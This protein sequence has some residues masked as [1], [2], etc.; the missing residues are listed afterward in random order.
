MN[1][2]IDRIYAAEGDKTLGGI[3]GWFD[4][5]DKSKGLGTITSFV[6][7]IVTLAV[8]FSFV[9]VTIMVLYSA[10]LYVSSLG[11]EAKA[12]TAKKTLIWA[13]VGFVVIGLA[14]VIKNVMKKE[15]G[16]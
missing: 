7:N 13:I 9:L 4:G 5:T 6:G 11:E 16:A 10:F 2:I 15:T 8:D 3:L 1:Q 14:E 12:E